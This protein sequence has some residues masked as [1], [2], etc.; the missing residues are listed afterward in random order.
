MMVCEVSG[1][2]PESYKRYLAI[3]NNFLAFSFAEGLFFSSP[4]PSA[5]SVC[6]FNLC[7]WNSL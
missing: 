3:L 4:L 6:P 2:V 5:I 1:C 7:F